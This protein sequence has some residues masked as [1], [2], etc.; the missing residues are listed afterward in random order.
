MIEADYAD[1]VTIP[2]TSEGDKRLEA[3]EAI[4]AMAQEIGIK[5]E[6][7]IKPSKDIWSDR[8][9]YTSN[10][11]TYYSWSAPRAD[12]DSRLAASWRCDGW[13]NYPRYCNPEVDRLLDEGA[14]IYDPAKAKEVY[15][16][17]I[18]IIVDDAYK[19]FTVHPNIYVVASKKVQNFVW[20]PLDTIIRLRDL[21]LEK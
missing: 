2:L 3:A 20:I 18:R 14:K 19:V 21:W 10:Y 6:I 11:S 9:L 7:D 17:L 15:N 4:Q 16:K 12:P 5:F 13:A 8:V 1:G